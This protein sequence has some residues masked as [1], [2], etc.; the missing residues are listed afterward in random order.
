MRGT[1]AL[2]RPLTRDYT[3]EPQV[4]AQILTMQGLEDSE[5]WRR[6]SLENHLDP[7]C[8]FP[9]SLVCWI[10]EFMDRGDSRRAWDVVTALERR[11][12][13]IVDRGLTRVYDLR[14]DQI[15]D[16]TLDLI[17]N[18]YHEWLS[19]EPPHEFWEIRFIFCL[20]RKLISHVRRFIR[21]R[22]IEVDLAGGIQS[23][24]DAEDPLSR[25][26]DQRSIDTENAAIA[27][28]ALDQLGYPLNRAFFLYHYGELTQEQIAKVLGVT[29][30]TVRNWL[31]KAEDLLEI[32]RSQE[33]Y[34][35]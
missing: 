12:A 20:K 32:R 17:T 13:R 16:L 34:I 9:E 35:Q 31:R 25:L 33:G 5:F 22:D 29:E 28:V 26:S 6:V 23:A 3:R 18:L 4:V 7:D 27:N 2:L 21:D 10:R 11:V 30:R 14:Q 19:L 8:P 1:H 24:A 15:E